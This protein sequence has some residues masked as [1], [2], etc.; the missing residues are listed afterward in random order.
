[1]KD[2]FLSEPESLS[3]LYSSQNSGSTLHT[4]FKKGYLNYGELILRSILLSRLI[5]KQTDLGEHVG[6]LLPNVNAFPIFF[7]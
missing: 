5:K 3:L 7:K 1:M 6:M 2:S 4:Q